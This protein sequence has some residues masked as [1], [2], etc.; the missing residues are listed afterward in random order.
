MPPRSPSFSVI[1]AELLLLQSPLTSVCL[2]GS[3][4][5]W[6]RCGKC[7]R[8]PM[9][10]GL[11]TP[12]PLPSCPCPP[13]LQVISL[14]WFWKFLC[15][16]SFPTYLCGADVHL[17]HLVCVMHRL[18]LAWSMGSLCTGCPLCFLLCVLAGV[19]DARR[20]SSWL[21][22]LVIVMVTH[23][24]RTSPH[25]ALGQGPVALVCVVLTRSGG[26]QREARRL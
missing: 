25:P 17:M 19:P 13:C 18:I 9:P 22:L 15:P 11:C 23:F 16:L 2:T 7:P 21:V 5:A 24:S 20:Q 12:A 14:P 6:A 26:Q 1:K 4:V 8:L 3:L 10:Q